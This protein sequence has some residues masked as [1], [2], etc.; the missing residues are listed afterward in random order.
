MGVK[1]AI[2]Q[3]RA[4]VGL[5]RF[6][7]R[8]LTTAY[9]AATAGEFEA[10]VLPEYDSFA[11]LLDRNPIVLGTGDSIDW[12]TLRNAELLIWEW[13]WTSAPARRM[14]EIRE[15]F[16]I[17]TLMFPGPLD[18]FWRELAPEDLEL[19]LEAA[20]ASDAIGAMLEDT[21]PFYRA[22]VPGAHVF[23]LPVPVDIEKFRA[24][25]LPPRDRDRELLLLTAP[26][27]FTGPA[28]QLSI[29]TFVA[30][31]SLLDR[32]PNLRGICFVY[33]EQERTGTE[34]ALRALG[35]ARYVEIRSYMGPIQ[36]YLSAVAPC[37][38]GLALP[39]GL[40]QGRNAMTSACL[41][42]PMVG[43][44][45][46]ETHRR[47]FPRTSVR[48]YDAQTAADLCLRLLDD[49]DF[50]AAVV[51]EASERIEDYSVESCRLRLE[52]GAAAAIARRR[53]TAHR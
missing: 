43:S 49:D 46:I 8:V 14:L 11:D 34:R 36:R 53:A 4:H 38:A 37:W 29:A 13:G 27:R 10:V 48:W 31:R 51:A 26:T 52:A 42:I 24:A 9:Q 7:K 12:N 17:P 45:E 25:G 22:L 47:L 20:A 2:L 16:N 21:V 40:L 5:R 32:K 6:G 18:R 28:S 44:E 15:R 30:F 39:H 41:C 1:T 23:H 33:D 19:Q 3:N 35:L 50:R